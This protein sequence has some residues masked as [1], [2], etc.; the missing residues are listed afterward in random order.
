M[1][2]RLDSA[3][4]K[5]GSRFLT[6]MRYMRRPYECYRQWKSRYGDTFEVNALNGNVIAT[7]NPENLRTALAA[8][9]DD[10]CQFAT[11]TTAPLVGPSSVILIDG[12]RHRQERRI[13]SPSFSG[14]CLQHEATKIVDVADEAADRWRVGDTIKI[15]DE[16][17]DVSLNVIIRVVFG[18][19]DESLMD[20][21]RKQIKG[22]V[23]SFHPLLAFTKIFQWHWFGLSPWIRFQRE[24]EA[25]EKMLDAEIERE[26]QA[27]HNSR[28][29]LPRI[30]QE[31]REQDGSVDRANVR[32][33]LITMLLAGHETTQIAIAWAMSWLTRFPKYAMQLR[34]ELVSNDLPTVIKSSQLL[35]GICNETLRLNPILPDVVRTLKN[36]MTWSGVELGPG[37]NIALATSLV[38]EDESI[39]PHP[40]QFKPERWFDWKAKPHQFLPFG[41]GA[42]RCLG[43]PLSLLELKIVI[44][45]W[46]SR[47]EFKLPAN[48]SE[49]E[50]VARR[51]LTMA[52]RSGIPLLISRKI[53]ER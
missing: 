26:L 6:T 33:Q 13:L 35:N 43:A 25:F 50:P 39:Y 34:D 32:A 42:R 21:F 22:F 31:Y 51:S 14:A 44:L 27:T 49:C 8:S 17:L 30:L 48:T 28:G 4:P 19:A 20:R 5:T 46:L 36:P 47:F 12:P 2:R 15:M 53:Q 24:K 10:V 29:M 45:R 1:R 3:F 23:A 9:T 16:A 37:T 38:H 52:P 11:E 18:V 40:S 41:G 7:C